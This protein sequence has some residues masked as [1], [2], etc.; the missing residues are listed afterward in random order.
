ME[1]ELRSK[2]RT[3]ELIFEW[4]YLNGERWNGKGYDINGNKVLEIENGIGK[5]KE[6]NFYGKLEYE[7]EYINGIRNGKGKEYKG[8]KII[9]EGEFIKWKRKNGIIKEYSYDDILLYEGEYLNWER[10]GKGKEY[11]KNNGRLIF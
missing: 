10:N 5:G 3:N 6:Y 11:E 7:G 8:D 1:I 2:K 9:F 4:E